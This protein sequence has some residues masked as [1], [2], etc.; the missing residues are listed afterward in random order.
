MKKPMSKRRS[1]SPDTAHTSRNDE[2]RMASRKEITPQ[3]TIDDTIGQNLGPRLL[4]TYPNQ[5]NGKE[6]IFTTSTAE[7]YARELKDWVMGDP[8]A[9]KISQFLEKKGLLRRTWSKWLQKSDRLADMNDFALMVIG[10][11]RE[12]GL[13]TRKYD[14]Q[15]TTFTMIHY[16]E[17]WRNML[18]VKAKI[19]NAEGIAS[20][21]R[22][23]VIE[24]YPDSPHV[25]VKVI[26]NK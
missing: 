4:D 10:N 9:L 25:P 26:E 22:I 19:M 11:R 7:R 12:I 21:Q 15:S 3:I 6:E 14:S 2:L 23:V 17:E 24:K 16:D 20:G 13:L 18:S 1:V 8:E 5:L